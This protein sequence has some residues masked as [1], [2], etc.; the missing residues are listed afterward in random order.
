MTLRMSL[1]SCVTLGPTSLAPNLMTMLF[2][3][4]SM[5]LVLLT[6]LAIALVV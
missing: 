2:G 3:I 1:T 6:P 5:G 4:L